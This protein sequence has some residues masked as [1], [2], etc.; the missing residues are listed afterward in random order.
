MTT[1]NTE[2]KQTLVEA[3][4]QGHCALAYG[5]ANV[6][7]VIPALER[8]AACHIDAAHQLFSLAYKYE[9]AREHMIEAKRITDQI[10]R[11]ASTIGMPLANTPVRDG[12]DRVS[13]KPST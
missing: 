4:S 11:L 2:Q 6:A 5:S 3:D 1:K 9:H 8:I 12:E 7:M 10:A 13:S